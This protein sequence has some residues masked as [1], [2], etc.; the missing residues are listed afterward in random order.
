MQSERA[1]QEKS[2]NMQTSHE[3]FAPIRNATAQLIE[4]VQ[5]LAND[6]RI[7]DNDDVLGILS[8][9]HSIQALLPQQL[10][11]ANGNNDA[12]HNVPQT[13]GVI[14]STNGN[15][16]H[17][18]S[19]LSTTNG[20][21][22]HPKGHV[23]NGKA[24]RVITNENGA[25]EMQHGAHEVGMQGRSPWKKLPQLK[26][27]NHGVFFNELQRRKVAGSPDLIKIPVSGTYE[28]TKRSFSQ[29]FER[30]EHT[31]VLLFSNIPTVVFINDDL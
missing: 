31:Y 27:W 7:A 3:V 23:S 21:G 29:M 11:F 15:G 16:A 1:L 18:N 4:H 26:D 13:N 22:A 2:G 25:A 14:P 24:H 20:N 12:T 28:S 6:A 8:R 19:H 30:I 5:N 17:T 10:S 9:L